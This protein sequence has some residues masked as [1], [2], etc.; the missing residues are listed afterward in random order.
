M[1]RGY[2]RRAIGGDGKER[3][4]RRTL[5]YVEETRH[6]QRR[7]G[8]PRNPLRVCKALFSVDSFTA[9]LLTVHTTDREA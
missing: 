9:C 5:R 8:P 4:R 1:N 3:R 2:D 6:S 7:R